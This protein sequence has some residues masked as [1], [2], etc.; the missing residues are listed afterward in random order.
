MR[1]VEAVG[2][3]VMVVAFGL[4]AFAIGLSVGQR[5]GARAGWKE[6]SVSASGGLGCRAA[7][8]VGG[9]PFDTLKAMIARDCRCGLGLGNDRWVGWECAR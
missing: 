6:H 7:D 8:A 3:I 9:E 5:L 1:P 2:V 4:A